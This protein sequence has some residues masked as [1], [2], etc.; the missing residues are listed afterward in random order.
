[1]FE[2]AWMVIENVLQPGELV[3]ISA[4][5]DKYA[6]V[7]TDPIKAGVFL[8]ELDDAA[9]QLSTLETWVMKDAYLT[10]AS[11]IDATRVAFDYHR[12]AHSVPSAPLVGLHAWIRSRIGETKPRIHDA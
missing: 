6:L 10:A 1:M 11:R 5:A 2:H 12:G 8:A 7:F 3:T 9:L 4:G